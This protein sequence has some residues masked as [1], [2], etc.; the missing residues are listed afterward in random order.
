M[1]G[2]LVILFRPRREPAGGQV[3]QRGLLRPDAGALGRRSFC[4]YDT[5]RGGLQFVERAAWVP[6]LG[7]QLLQRRRRLQPADGAADRDRVLHRRAHHV[8]ARTPGEG[9]LRAST[10]CS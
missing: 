9:V 5:G 6:S 7:I 3:G 10:S 8:G 2:L 4:T 1:T